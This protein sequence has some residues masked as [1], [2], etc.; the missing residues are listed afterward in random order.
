MATLSI[1]IVSANKSPRTPPPCGDLSPTPPHPRCV[2]RRRPT[3]Y[4]HIDALITAI[5]EAKTAELRAQVAARSH[6]RRRP[7]AWRV[8]KNPKRETLTP[9]RENSTCLYRCLERSWL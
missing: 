1:D 3:M 4:S 2:D 8:G 7:A 9:V 5:H 6:R